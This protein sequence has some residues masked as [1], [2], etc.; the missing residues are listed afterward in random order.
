[1]LKNGESDESR[2]VTVVGPDLT[3]VSSNCLLVMLKVRVRL[4]WWC[5]ELNNRTVLTPTLLLLAITVKP[6]QAYPPPPHP[7]RFGIN[8]SVM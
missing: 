6:G 2:A 4:V 8:E 3:N 1:M 5:V 7:P